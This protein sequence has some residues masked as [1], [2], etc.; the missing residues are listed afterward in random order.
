MT[1]ASRCHH[2]FRKCLSE[3]RGHTSIYDTEVMHDIGPS[4]DKSKEYFLTG[5]GALFG[6]EGLLQTDISS[7]Q[8]FSLLISPI[9]PFLMTCSGYLPILSDR[10]LHIL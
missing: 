8:L 3:A 1:K 9:P 6:I 5:V 10:V 7:F 4:H 2:A